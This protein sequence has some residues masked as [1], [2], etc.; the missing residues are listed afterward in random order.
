MEASFSVEN[1]KLIVPAHLRRG[2]PGQKQRI[3]AEDSGCEL[4]DL[5]RTRLQIQDFSN[6][7]ILDIGCGTRIPEAL[8]GKSIPIRR[9]VG[10][11]VDEELVSFLNCHIKDERLQ[12]FRLNVHNRNYNPS[13]DLLMPDSRLPIEESFDVICLFS[14]FT[15]LDPRDSDCMLAILNRYISSSGKLIFTCFLDDDISGFDD[16]NP[17]KPLELAVY[18]TSFMQHLIARNGW[19]IEKL[20]PPTQSS[21]GYWLMQHCFVCT[22]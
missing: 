5:M 22:L 1:Y 19:K 8:L 6:S 10:M 14:V 3:T 21:S 13:G 16:M 11:D 12:F 18:S 15:H 9:Y 17:E 20:Y 2:A 4:L 7:S